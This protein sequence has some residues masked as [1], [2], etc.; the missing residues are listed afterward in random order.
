MFSTCV[1][2]IYRIR[3]L[4]TAASTNDPN[5]DN[6]DAAIWSFLEVTIAIIAACLPTLRPFFSKL[7]PRI[8]ASSLGR[9]SHP[10]KYGHYI[11]TPSSHCLRNM[12]K[13]KTQGRSRH[14]TD[15]TSTLRGDDG[16]PLPSPSRSLHPR[17]YPA[18]SVSI[19]AGKK[20][21]DHD[22]EPRSPRRAET[23][24][25]NKGGIQATTVVTQQVTMERV[26]EEEWDTNRPSCS[27]AT[28]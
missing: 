7:M 19:I 15:D 20:S 12:P 14:S 17:A 24:V 3:T 25:T 10:S 21:D 4:K 28:L 5:W 2:S 18:V 22:E 23:V 6:V 13:S 16:I 27:E 9:S 1:I 8:F 11:Q 26:S